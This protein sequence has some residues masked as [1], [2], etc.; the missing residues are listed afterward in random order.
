M[1]TILIPV[2]FS[3]SSLNA[4]DYAMHF[5]E[6]VRGNVTL[7][8]V[9]QVPVAYS[10]IPVSGQ[11]FSNL[12]EDA[13]KKITELRHE[14]LRI[15]GNKVVINTAIREGY[16][17][18]EIKELSDELNSF[19]VVMGTSGS[20]A[21]ERIL[22]GS[23]TLQAISHI[24]APLII[25]PPGVKFKSIS[26]IGLA[27]DM[28]NV[29][30]S[31]HTEEIIKLANDFHAQLHILHINTGEDNHYTDARISGSEEL[32]GLF[33]EQKPQFHFVNSK[34]IEDAINEFAEKN[35]LDLLVVI[36]KKHGLLEGIF[37]KSHTKK[38]AL[39]SHVPVMA[40][41]E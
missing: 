27:C 3:A 31:V 15:W 38:I 4:V 36:P 24:S 2:D 21:M 32:L 23:N 28:L 1:K 16:V 37:H 35:N 22:F 11:D 34:N 25:V 20:S 12:I 5:A 33:K 30:K 18:A 29:V 13:T 10:E 8:Y 7:M 39:L 9:C 40:V 17:V 26:Q 6:S 41:H 19:A 14:L